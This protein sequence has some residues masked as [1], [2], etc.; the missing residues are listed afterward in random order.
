[1]KD[2]TVEQKFGSVNVILKGKNMPP[3]F[4]KKPY[5][6]SP[7]KTRGAYNL[8]T[9]DYFKN[10]KVSGELTKKVMID[11]AQLWKT[12]TDVQKKPYIDESQ[13]DQQ[14]YI[15]QIKEF[16]ENGFYTNEDGTDAFESEKNPKRKYGRDVLLPNSPKCAYTS[17]LSANIKPL[18]DK[19]KI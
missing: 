10:Y 6:M 18:M 3:T 1:M 16:K 14:R 15:R 8:F 19:E 7:T 5:K 11:A 13:K 9:S 2:E 17:F 12:F 4:P